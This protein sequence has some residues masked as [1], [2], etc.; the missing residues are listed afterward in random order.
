M[1]LHNMEE[2]S[3]NYVWEI[4]EQKNLEKSILKLQYY[5]Y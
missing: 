4:T 2:H 1:D 5:M 3:T